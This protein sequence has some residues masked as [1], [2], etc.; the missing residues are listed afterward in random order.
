MVSDQMLQE[1]ALEV[2]KVASRSTAIKPALDRIAGIV[3]LRVPLEMVRLCEVDS[4]SGSVLTRGEWGRTGVKAPVTRHSPMARRGQRLFRSWIK[5]NAISNSNDEAGAGLISALLG[6]PVDSN[7]FAFPVVGEQEIA[8][9]LLIR[10]V[11][12][13]R[14]GSPHLELLGALAEPFAVLLANNKRI[15]ELETRQ[16]AAEADKRT[17]LTK[18]GREEL[19]ETII[20]IS[21]GLCAVMSRVDLI[22]G[23]DMPVLLLGETGSGKEL[24]ARAIHSRSPRAGGPFIRVNCGAIPSELVDSQLFGHE[25]G[26]FTGATSTVRG[27][28]ERAND[29]TLLLDEVAELPLAAQVRLL[30][31]LQEGSLERVGG[32]RSIKVDVRIVAATH[33]DLPARVQAG[34][35]REDLW[36]RIFSFPIL[37]PPLRDRKGDLPVL[38]SHFAERA[39]RRFGL[40][41]CA[42]T[43]QDLKLLAEYS[44][45]GNIRELASVIDRAAILGDGERLAV[46]ESLG[47]STEQS[48]HRDTSS[49]DGEIAI[50][51]IE[52]L[53]VAMRAHIERALMATS[54]RIEG[55]NGAARILRINPHTLRARMRKLGIEWTAFREG[56]GSRAIPACGRSEVRAWPAT[57]SARRKQFSSSQ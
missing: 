38:A 13:M 8:A 35:F 12:S 29:G 44:W 33:R 11:N 55:P 37:L 43:P 19:A 52:P 42:P 16:R 51:R 10:P 30:R 46:A 32:E 27:W 18:L 21:G 45:P 25:R 2:W 1:T 39:A 57:L 4:R 22:A 3:S 50:P 20:G 40:R 15:V 56:E 48:A 47:T 34:R 6:G 49:G 24:I 23:C 14:R 28:F 36:Y 53:D 7:W 5:A 26:A 31:V 41:Y 17:A 9:A 54:G